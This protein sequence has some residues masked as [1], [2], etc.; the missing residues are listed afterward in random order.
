MTTRS[1][2]LPGMAWGPSIDTSGFAS[3][4]MSIRQSS[5]AVPSPRWAEWLFDATTDEHIVTTLIIPNN[6]VSI[7]TLH[8]YFK[9][10]SAT[11]SSVRWA[12]QI[13]ALT[14][15]DSVDLDADSFATEEAAS[16]AVP[17]TAGHLRIA[18]ILFSVNDDGI[19]AGDFVT[20]MLRRDP[21]HADDAASG[22]AEFIGAEFRYEV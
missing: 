1:L 6:F 5:S 13:H 9:M 17:A 14:N 11:S 7:P 2:S 18:R 15:T 20:I 3:A 19:A 10:A 4:A 21:D 22:D 12:A 8:V 16:A